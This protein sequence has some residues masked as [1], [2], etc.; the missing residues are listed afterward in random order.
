MKPRK[1]S[2][3]KFFTITHLKKRARTP[4]RLRWK[5]LSSLGSPDSD[6]FKIAHYF[7]TESAAKT[8]GI[9]LVEEL[10]QIGSLANSMSDNER[11]D[12]LRTA[13]TLKQKGV[14]PVKAMEEG[15]RLLISYGETAEKRIGDFWEPYS[16]RNAENWSER[17][18]RAQQAFFESVKDGIMREPVKA[19][20]NKTNA[21]GL[22]QSCLASYKSGGRRHALN[23]LKHARSKIRSFLGFISEQVDQLSM[24]LITDIFTAKTILPARLE[25]EADNVSITAAQA[26]YLLQH[27][28]GEEMAGWLVL[29][30]FMGARTMLLQNWN[31]S[32]INWEDQVIHIPK[33]L[34][35]L[36][37]TDVKFSFSEVPNFEAWI[38]WA[39][40]KDGRPKPQEKIAK[41]SQPTMT[42]KVCKAINARRNLFGQDGRVK[43]R[44]AKELRN[45]MRS[46]FITYG[47][48]RMSVGTVSKIAEDHFS[49]HKY[50]A[51]DVASGNRPESERFWSLTPESLEPHEIEISLSMQGI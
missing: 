33:R 34:T 23:T 45:F 31:W 11:M 20:L 21:I 43:I 7:P 32:I 24:S 3:E 17:H 49:L 42:R 14:D 15:F 5:A 35:K 47:I 6:D 40:E 29:K 36:K 1:N 50:I 41:Y 27:L 2:A 12:I 37:K 30:L 19:F 22:I 28:Q 46:G 25:A 9:R 44:P 48:E 39:W 4:F 10:Q 8:F 16:T 38:K 13:A 26:K 18:K 51:S